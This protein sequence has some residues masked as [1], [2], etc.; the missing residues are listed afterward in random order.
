MYPFALRYRATSS[1]ADGSIFL[2]VSHLG[3][4]VTTDGG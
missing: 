1:A 2:T 4:F 3:R